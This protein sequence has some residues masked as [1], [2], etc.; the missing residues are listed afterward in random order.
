MAIPK[1]IHQT[2]ARKSDLTDAFRANISHIKQLNGTWTHYL[3]DDAECDRFIR[4][5]YDRSIYQS[6]VRIDPAYGAAKAD[7]FR[8]L[9]LYKL[10]GV[11]LDIKSTTTKPLDD[12][13]RPNDAFILSH[14]Q[15]KKGQRY[16]RWGMWPELDQ[17]GEYLTWCIVSAPNHPFLREV[18]GT[19]QKNIETYD[20]ARDGAGKLAVLRITGP[21]AYTLA[22]HRIRNEYP[23]RYA[24]VDDLGFKYSI[25]ENDKDRLAHESQFKSH[26][27]HR[28]DPVVRPA[29]VNELGGLSRSDKLRDETFQRA[30]SALQAGN[31][32]DA[33]RLFKSV[34]GAQ[35]R[36]VAALNLLGIAL[37]Q[38]GRFAEAE[39]YL[40]RALREHAG[41]DATLY[42]YGIILKALDRPAEALERFS[43]ALAINAAAPESWNNRGTVFNDLNRYDDA[44]GDFETAIKLNPR[45]ADAFCNKGK[46]LTSLKRWDEAVSAYQQAINLKPDFAEAWLGRGNALFELKSYDEA[47]A[48]FRRASALKPNLAEAWLGQGN[49][50]TELRHYDE[51]FAAHDKALALKPDL[52][53]AWLGRG[54]FSAALKRYDDAIAAFDRARALKPDLA[55]AWFGR[56]N[57]LAELN[58]YDE[59]FAAC[60]KAF[61]LKP[62]LDYLAG[63]RLQAK[64]HMAD[65]SN[66]EAETAQLLSAIRQHKPASTPF[67]ILALASSAAD[68]LQCAKR[69]VEDQP[70]FPPL[71]RGEVYPHDR[72]RVAYVS[73][74]LH[75]HATAFLTA[76][77][78]EHHDS[79]RFEVTAISLGAEQDSD[80][81][82]RLKASFERFVDSRSHG[83][84]EIAELVRQLEIDIVVDLKGF[85]RDSRLGILARRAAPVQVSW[86][87]YPGTMGADYID[88]VIADRTVIPQHHFESYS[89]KVVWLP[90][91]YQ[92]NDSQRPIAELTPTRRALD[93]PEGGFV[94]CC[95]NNSYKITPTLFDAW[96]RLLQAVDG[97]VLWLLE[98]NALASRNLRR[99]AERRGVEPQRLVFAPRVSPADH[100]ARHRQADLFLDTLPYNAHTTASDALWAGLPVIT[101]LGSTFAGRVAASLLD[102][103]G[104]AELITT[105][106]DDYEALALKL[107]R[108]RALLASIK[109][110]LIRNRGTY[111]LFDTRR[112]TRHIEAAYVAMWQAY[113]Q[114][115]PPASFAVKAGD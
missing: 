20:P 83:D 91:S 62:D 78:F 36:H 101:C 85:T 57:A 19:V 33:A 24:D 10:G 103:I 21:I 41:S 2:V 110:K 11:Y 12:V 71:W 18:I 76:G 26:Y 50:L 79:S 4:T 81:R 15:N 115:R 29:F 92:V 28:T 67:P 107:A 55:E 113:Q 13:L 82:R 104:L 86:L 93:L 80:L 108:D 46:S 39:T 34:L 22:I 9:V 74:D 7:F 99:E 65:W 111:P 56:G 70:S 105:T 14:W 64:L 68:Q 114:G 43:Q 6:Y 16:E 60:D 89:E 59:A 100:L 52:A 37:T 73:A 61:K 8:Y 23:W 112:F 48:A 32:E 77:L 1:L 54:N 106:I 63:R 47:F 88:Y 25:L 44:V 58:R 94:F 5:H 31:V 109:A 98:D 96:M 35:P 30:L 69:Y 27:S 102:A 51:A 42:N 66:L 75:E 95:F 17:N 49:V 87:G 53:E 45:Y 84:R 90:D 72:V 38:L 3:Y 40:R 97:S